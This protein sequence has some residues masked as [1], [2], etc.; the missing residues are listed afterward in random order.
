MG[1]LFPHRDAKLLKKNSIMSLPHYPV[2]GVDTGMAMMT[3]LTETKT[4]TVGLHGF[5]AVIN[6]PVVLN[7]G[8][9]SPYMLYNMESLIEICQ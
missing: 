3:K 5:L 8:G 9:V 1:T 6:Y 7:R 2:Q 4:L